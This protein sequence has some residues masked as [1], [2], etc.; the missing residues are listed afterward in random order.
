MITPV[1][2]EVIRHHDWSAERIFGRPRSITVSESPT[3]P[4]HSAVVVIIAL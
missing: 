4:L 3:M 2:T 1:P